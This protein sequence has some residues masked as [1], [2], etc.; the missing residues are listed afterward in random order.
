MGYPGNTDILRRQASLAIL[1]VK[2][3]GSG[4]ESRGKIQAIAVPSAK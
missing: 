1:Y 4:H 3:G 2:T